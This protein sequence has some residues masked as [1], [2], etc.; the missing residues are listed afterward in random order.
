MSAVHFEYE[1]PADEYVVAQ[2]L[3]HK[4]QGSQ[5]RIRRAAFW[6]L[7]GVVLVVIS[8][9]LRPPESTPSDASTNLAVILLA[10]IGAW[11]IYG[12][13]RILFPARYFRRAYRSFEFAGKSFKA[14]VDDDGFQIAGEFCEWR[15]K[16]PAVR[17][18]GED[19]LVFIFFAGG[20][21]YIFGKKFLSGDQQQELRKFIEPKE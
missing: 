19:E 9:N 8:W 4:L 16:W 3:Y 7:G 13:S 5:S 10:A 21:I 15:V 2:L 20:T 6:I 1:I 18:K 14:D 12:G 11:W 17:V